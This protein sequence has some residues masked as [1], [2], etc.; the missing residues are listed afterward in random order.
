MLEQDKINIIKQ[1]QKNGYTDSRIAKN[2]STTASSLRE[3]RL[4][5][6]IFY[7]DA[8][9]NEYLKLAIELEPLAGEVYFPIELARLTNKSISTVTMVCKM[10]NVKPSKKAYCLCCGKELKV[11]TTAVPSYCNNRCRLKYKGDKNVNRKRN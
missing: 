4:K 2:L 11:K 9:Y 5:H 6:R 3:Y 1:L 8:R 10:F 7:E